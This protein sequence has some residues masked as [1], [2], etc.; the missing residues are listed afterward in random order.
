MYKKEHEEEARIGNITGVEKGCVAMCISLL[1]Q[2][3]EWYC[4]AF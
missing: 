1:K 3:H 4:T 2:K